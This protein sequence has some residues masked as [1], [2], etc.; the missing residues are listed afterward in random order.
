MTTHNL[1]IPELSDIDLVYPLKNDSCFDII[2][3][4]HF[5]F[6]FYLLTLFR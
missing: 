3:Y 2:L 1:F 6:Y 5:Y 4:F